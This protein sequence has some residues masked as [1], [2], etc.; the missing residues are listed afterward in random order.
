MNSLLA[1]VLLGLA[2]LLAPSAAYASCGGGPSAEHVY[3]ECVPSGSGGKRTT[4]PP[5]TKTAGSGPSSTVSP[6][7]A[8][9]LKNAG[10]DSRV[11]SSF[12]AGGRRVLPPSRSGAEGAGPSIVSSAFDLGSGPL[13]LL[14][15]LAGSAVLFLGMSALRGRRGTRRG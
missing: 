15:G 11:L 13:A 8:T 3:S 1:V 4:T 10:K 14:V 7:I 6:R 5:T 2:L 9:A 12:V